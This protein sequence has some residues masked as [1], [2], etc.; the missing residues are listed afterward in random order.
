MIDPAPLTPTTCLAA[1]LTPTAAD[2]STDLDVARRYFASVMDDGVDGL[3]VAVHTGRGDRLDIEARSTLISRAREVS[4]QVVTAVWSGDDP[5]WPAEAEGAG[6][7]ALLIAPGYPDDPGVEA[8]RLDRIAEASALPLIAFD[9][10]LRPY[11]DVTREAVLAHPA[12]RAFKS[13]RM[14]DAIASQSGIRAAQRHGVPVL[15]GEDRMFVPSL[16]WGATGAL[17]GI[18][19][20]ATA[21]TVR[22]LSAFRAGDGIV[23]ASRALDSLA[24][25]TFRP[26]FDG[27]VQRM[28]WIA[29]AEGRIPAEFAHDP[30]RPAQLSDDERD[31]V[32]RAAARAMRGLPLH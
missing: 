2:G 8:Q 28:A 4:G 13:A 23:A 24:E 7:T 11:D 12:V 9:L 30:A 5:V 21:V 27:Y 20:A 16:M 1:V 19:A 10:Y 14:H 3:A 22:A 17:V 6:A 18:G 32:V 29:A 31:G 25:A 15:T 26:P